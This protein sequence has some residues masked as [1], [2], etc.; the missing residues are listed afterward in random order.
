MGRNAMAAHAPDSPPLFDLGPEGPDFLKERALLSG[1]C[2]A[3]AGVDEAGRGPLAG[4]VVAAAVVLDPDRPIAGLDDS[5]ALT[6]RRR[7]ALFD[8]IFDHALAI[9][10]GSACA[11]H[12]D[13]SDI[14]KASLSA[15]AQCIASLSPRA[16]GALFDGRDVPEG[17]PAG[18]KAEAVIKGDARCLSIAA[19]SIIAKVTRDRMLEQLCIAHSGYGLSGHKGYGSAA[20]RDAIGRLGGIERVH[21]FSFRPLAG[22]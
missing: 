3:V 7:E 18:V 19:A 13:R 10:I 21:R 14:R 5:K 11:A 12:I 17:L 2:T 20:H 16:N 1:G 15:M 9:S 6:A 4:S 8:A 22:S